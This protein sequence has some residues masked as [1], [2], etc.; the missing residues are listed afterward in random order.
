MD[1]AVRARSL[2][3]TFPSN[4]K[5]AL[6]AL[7]LEIEAGEMLAIT[8]PSGS[9]KSTALYAMAGLIGLDDG[10][11]DVFDQT[12]QTKADW[13]RLRAQTIGLV[14]Q[15]DWLMPTLSALQNV[16]LPLIGA[17]GAGHDEQNA[18]AKVALG[19]VGMAHMAHRMPAG[20]SGGERQRVAIARALV[21]RPRIL[22][23]DEPTGELDQANSRKV[24]DLLAAL[25]RDTGTTVVI[26]TH[27]AE[28]A[29]ACA[30]TLRI[31]DGKVAEDSA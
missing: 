1:L 10:Q 19:S 23:A 17:G 24:V 22:L 18:R 20:L 2:Y 4:E 3:K 8:G 12:P 7:S 29:G 21:G 6:D 28:V 5:P 11:V 25:N 30:R 27:D 15:E 31:V 26:V 14:F 16:A 9:G 13:A